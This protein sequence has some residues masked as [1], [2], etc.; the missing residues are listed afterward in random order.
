MGWD[1]IVVHG[2]FERMK[3]D[4]TTRNDRSSQPQL[5]TTL[6][7]PLLFNSQIEMIHCERI[8]IFY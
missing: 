4:R 1:E 6:F 3:K 2:R 5:K 8:F 7:F